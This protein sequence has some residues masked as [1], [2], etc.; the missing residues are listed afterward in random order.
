MGS[1]KDAG[2]VPTPA[3][4]RAQTPV[5]GAAIP[6]TEAT[7]GTSQPVLVEAAS[8]SGDWVCFCQARSDDDGDGEVRVEVAVGGRLTGDRLARFVALSD[9]SERPVDDLM[10]ASPDGRWL[11]TRAGKESQLI[12]ARSGAGSVLNV[13]ARADALPFLDHRSV[14]FDGV[15]RRLS[16]IRGEGKRRG[17]VVRDLD[18]GRESVT[19]P[20]AGRLHRARLDFT[21]N[22]IVFEV[23]A[24]DSNGNGRLDLPV[25]DAP[26]GPRPCLG[27]IP[28]FASWL[29]RGDRSTLRVA[30]IGAEKTQS[31]P[32]LVAPLDRHLLVRL[33]GDTLV[34]QSARGRRTRLGPGTCR[35][36]LIHA[37]VSREVALFACERADGP[38]QGKSE[39]ELWGKGTRRRLGIFVTPQATDTWPGPPS[40]LVP[41]YP[42]REAVLVDLERNRTH[43]L[44]AGDHVLAV[45]EGRAV[46]QREDMLVLVDVDGDTTTTLATIPDR[47]PDVLRR[48]PV[49]VVG[50]L[51][52]DAERGVVLG[53]VAGRPLAATRTGFVLVALG[54]DGDASTVGQGP[55]VW[56]R[57]VAP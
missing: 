27:P 11:V 45:A 5:E 37:D 48:P 55:L 12:D 30:A 23:V 24:N 1:A 47:F 29:G 10:A 57:P 9:G 16:Y 20:G 49:A 8:T 31:V 17:V 33:P 46:V 38:D 18:S 26:P 25:P 22:W 40:R 32:G 56:R 36:N 44:L 39:V 34:L 3:V 7:I 19:E 43:S 6:D 53:S 41:L 42:G 21:G 13:D 52:V 4:A 14:S 54:R 50:S 51:V 15:S 28:T 35:G 2:I